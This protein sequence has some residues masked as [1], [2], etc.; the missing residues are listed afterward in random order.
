L[1]VDD[2]VD[3]AANLCADFSDGFTVHPELGS[4]ADE[5]YAVDYV[6]GNGP[7]VRGAK[8]CDGMPTGH[9]ASGNTLEV[10]L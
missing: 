10:D 5:L 8:H 2:D 6:R 4:S 9:E 7:L 1:N 3:P